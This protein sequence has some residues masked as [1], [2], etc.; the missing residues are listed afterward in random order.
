MTPQNIR[1]QLRKTIDSLIALD[2]KKRD[3]E[4]NDT[5]GQMVTF[6]TDDPKAEALIH[7]VL[8]GAPDP[9]RALLDQQSEDDL[10]FLTALMWFG[11]ADSAAGPGVVFTDLLAAAKQGYGDRDRAVGYLEAKP[12][13]KYLPAGLQRLGYPR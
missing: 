5:K 7:K 8:W 9:V 1:P 3:A 11:R 2:V 4:S 10:C 6:G 12:L 13:A